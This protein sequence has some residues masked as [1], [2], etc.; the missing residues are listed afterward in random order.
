VSSFQAGN[1]QSPSTILA[2]KAT[3]TL[4]GPGDAGGGILQWTLANTPGA[5]NC[6]YPNTATLFVGP[7][8]NNPLAGARLIKAGITSTAW[9]YGVGN[10]GNCNWYSNALLGFSQIG[11]TLMIALFTDYYGDRAAPVD[12]IIY[13]LVP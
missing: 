8:A 2:G 1:Y 5:D 10:G 13:T 3:I 12:Q 6:T 7:I 4:T 11:N 9:S